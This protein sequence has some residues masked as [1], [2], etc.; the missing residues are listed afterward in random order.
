MISAPLS[1]KR[2]DSFSQ[3]EPD[4]IL[5]V[6]IIIFFLLM[7]AVKIIHSPNPLNFPALFPYKI[8][9]QVK[10][11]YVCMQGYERLWSKNLAE[12]P[13]FSPLLTQLIFL[14]FIKWHSYADMKQAYFFHRSLKL[15]INPDGFV[16]PNF[17]FQKQNWSG[18]HPI[19]FLHLSV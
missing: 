5:I 3:R 2:V 11:K 10:V 1:K 4:I 9:R 16:C 8:Q 6:L 19:I 12:A 17:C 7:F 18:S 14:L 15:I 13:L